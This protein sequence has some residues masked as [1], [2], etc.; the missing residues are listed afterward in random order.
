MGVVSREGV[1]FKRKGRGL[2]GSGCGLQGREVPHQG[3]GPA[4]AKVMW[5][6]GGG[7]QL[8]LQENELGSLE[9]DEGKQRQ[10]GFEDNMRGKKLSLYLKRNGKILKGLK[11][12]SSLVPFAYRKYTSLETL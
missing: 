2:K 6:K 12:G 3:E 9:G 10:V 1:W 8:W 7:I 5:Y 4:G 11:Q